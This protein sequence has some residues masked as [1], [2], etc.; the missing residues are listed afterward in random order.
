MIRHSRRGA[1]TDTLYNSFS[2]EILFQEVGHKSRVTQRAKLSNV[3]GLI[4]NYSN[5]PSSNE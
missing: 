5:Q 4:I 2:M 1:D 3:L